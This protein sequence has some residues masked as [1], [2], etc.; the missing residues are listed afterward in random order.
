MGREPYNYYCRNLDI[1]IKFNSKLKKKGE[2]NI[3]NGSSEERKYASDLNMLGRK[4]YFEEYFKGI[5]L[6]DQYF[7]SLGEITNP[8]ET[9]HFRRGYERGK[10]LVENNVIP[11][12]YKN[13]NENKKHR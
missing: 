4:A 11:L 5:K 3:K 12:E 8:K 13:I 1:D 10:F 6:E 7:D 2:Q 9:Y